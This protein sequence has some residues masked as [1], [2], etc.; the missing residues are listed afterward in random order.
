MK[1]VSRIICVGV[2]IYKNSPLHLIKP[3]LFVHHRACLLLP[4]QEARAWEDAS[5]AV[6][7]VRCL[8]VYADAV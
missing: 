5:G 7:A 6:Q 1:M 4:G 8:W 2:S 3:L